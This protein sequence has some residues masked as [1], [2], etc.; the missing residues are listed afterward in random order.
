MGVK[1]IRA[2]RESLAGRFRRGPQV[3]ESAPKAISQN[4]PNVEELL[5][6]DE[7]YR[8]RAKSGRL[9]RIAPRRFNPTH[10]AW[11]PVLHTARGSR[12]YT[13]LFSNTARA[14]ELGTVQ[15]WVVI[16]RDDHDGHGRWTVITARL[17]RLKGKRIVRGR[18]NECVEYYGQSGR[19]KRITN[20]GTGGPSRKV[21][22][23]KQ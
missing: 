10:E 22:A 21:A 15:D 2:I 13:A 3:P 18:E 1:R 23:K 6:V 20:D 4:Q 8:T 14:H 19:S 17:G 7:E 12:H 11:L 5:G 9:P 16:Y